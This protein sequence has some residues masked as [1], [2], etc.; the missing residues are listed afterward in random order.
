ME[1]SD[2]QLHRYKKAD[3]LSEKGKN[4]Y[5][6]SFNRTHII[7]VARE[8][9]EQHRLLENE[10]IRLAGRITAWREHGKNTFGDL[11]DESGRLQLYFKMDTLG[12][13]V[14][15]DLKFLDMGDW[16]G[17]E[18]F[19]FV[20]KKGELTLHVESL[21]LLSKSLR[22]LP[23]K[24]HGLKDVETRYRQRYLD[25]IANPEVK[26]T[27]IRRSRIVSEMR[28]F[29]ENEGFL[30]VE[31]P[32]LQPLVGGATA[33]PFITYHNTLEMN[34]YL[35]IAPELYL[36]RLMVG[37]FEK[38]FEIN[39]NFRNEG[40][41]TRHNPEFTMMELYQAYTDYQGMMDLTERMVSTIV[42]KVCGTLQVEYQ[43]QTINFAA[44]WRRISLY[45]SV[46]EATGVDV[47][48]IKDR[49]EAAEL[50]RKLKVPVKANYQKDKIISEIFEA[51]VE[52]T[53]I[54]PTF[55]TD[56]PLELSPLA[57]KHRNNPNLT[58]RFEFFI[59]GKEIGNAYSELNDPRDQR[60]RFMKQIE[61]REAGD[62]EAHMLDEDY[63]VALEH[64]MP[65]TGGLG[66][67]VDRLVML[68]TDSPSIRDVILFPHMR[69]RESEM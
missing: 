10:K 66:I 63:L 57:K 9:F 64:G 6:Y 53:L 2:I 47:S 14:Y 13:E 54:H 48:L 19:L 56:Y 67:G 25:L 1:L 26:N 58:E 52:P 24:W 35:R 23:E 30:E 55:I 62:E 42:Q 16:L 22:P 68:L 32:M 15:N 39:R 28:S 7:R 44:P 60:E 17:V 21:E 45:D 59:S 37:G 27:F 36:K 4:P 11:L 33:K 40:V 29:L 49:N 12:E 3:G 46:K 65:P 41:S 34:L 18:G 50:A 31:T 61:A 5:G 51:Y 69:S 8:G 20:T 38:V 43:G